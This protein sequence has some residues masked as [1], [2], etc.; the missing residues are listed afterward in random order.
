MRVHRAPPRVSASYRYSHRPPRPS[1]PVRARR[2][3]KSFEGAPTGR[4]ARRFV[5]RPALAWL[6][7]FQDK[8]PAT[9]PGRLGG[10][11]MSKNGRGNAETLKLRKSMDQGDPGKSREIQGNPG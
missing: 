2:S 10:I 5:A 11:R 8:P 7:S 6:A 4:K 9:F 3:K 1:D